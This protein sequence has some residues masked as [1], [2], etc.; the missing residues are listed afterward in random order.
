MLVIEGA[1]RPLRCI[2]VMCSPSTGLRPVT[3]LPIHTRLGKYDPIQRKIYTAPPS[4]L[5]LHLP[6]SMQTNHIYK[7]TLYLLNIS[8]NIHYNNNNI[9][10]NKPTQDL[11]PILILILNIYIYNTTTTTTNNNKYLPPHYKPFQ[12]K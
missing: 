9:H 12:P 7:S 3:P 4:I 11:I 8:L 10:N 5:N 6:T 2:D 1:S